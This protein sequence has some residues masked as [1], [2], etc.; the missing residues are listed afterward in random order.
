MIAFRGEFG[1]GRWFRVLSG[2]L[3]CQLRKREVRILKRGNDMA[4][5]GWFSGL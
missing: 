1:V 5:A 4:L 3:D 2:H